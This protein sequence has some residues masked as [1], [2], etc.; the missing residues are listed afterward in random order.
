MARLLT[1]S[2]GFMSGGQSEEE[3]AIG[4]DLVSQR[5]TGKA[6]LNSASADPQGET[7]QDVS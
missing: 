4:V 3:V 1:K 5:Q 2:D 6:Y 7:P